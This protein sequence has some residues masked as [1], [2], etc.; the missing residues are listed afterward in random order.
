MG[1]K[2]RRIDM[3]GWRHGMGRRDIE[4]KGNAWG[5]RRGGMNLGEGGLTSIVVGGCMRREM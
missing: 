5:A 2:E 1:G 4:M 3:D